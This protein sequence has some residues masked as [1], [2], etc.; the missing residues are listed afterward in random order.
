MTDPNH[1]FNSMGGAPNPSNTGNAQSGLPQFTEDEL[2]RQL[3]ISNFLNQVNHINQRQLALESYRQLR[4]VRQFSHHTSGHLPHG[5]LGW[6]NNQNF[7]GQ[8]GGH[9]ASFFTP[10][11]SVPH[12]HLPHVASGSL[13]SSGLG[14]S[15]AS[16]SPNH[17]PNHGRGFNNCFSPAASGLPTGLF[18]LVTPSNQTQ[19]SGFNNVFSNTATKQHPVPDNDS[20]PVPPESTLIARSQVPTFGN[21]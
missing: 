12:S 19:E 10:A 6:S 4:G 17:G 9:H 1:F 8:A 2:E 7:Q 21:K 14:R 15:N 20:S 5:G 16:Q 3:D 13:P 18:P 11:S